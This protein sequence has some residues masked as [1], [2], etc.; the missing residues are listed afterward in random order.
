MQR[1]WLSLAR[2]LVDQ[3]DMDFSFGA[4]QEYNGEQALAFFGEGVLTTKTYPNPFIISMSGVSLGGTVGNGIAFDPNGQITRVDSSSTT[5]KTFTIQ[6]ADPSLAR[7]DLLVMRYKSTG[8]I[9]VPKPSDPIVNVSLNLIDD[10]ELAVVKGTAAGSPAYPAKGPLD[11]IL[12]GLR[13]PAGAT[14]GTSVSVDLT[15][16]EVCQGNAFALPVIKQEVPTGAVD[17]V[18]ATFLTSAVPLTAQSV[19]VFLDGVEVLPADYT[20]SSQTLVFVTPPSLGQI[21]SVY[22]V[23]NG[24]S[25]TNPLQGKTETPSGAVDG[26][27]KLFTLT[28]TPIDHD[29]TIVFD[30][31]VKVPSG[32]WALIQN[33]SNPSQIQFTT[34]PTAG[35][36]ITVFYFVNLM[37]TG[38]SG[39]GAAA[40][41]NATNVGT[42]TG[43][44]KALSSGVLQFKSLTAGSNITIVDDGLGNV[45]LSSS[46][47][48][49]GGR[50]NVSGS[51]ASPQIVN[52]A[53]GIAASASQR[54]AY[55]LKGQVSGGAQPV[56]A[57]PQVAAGAVIGDERLFV[58]TNDT[59]Y[60]IFQDG[61]GL[62][63]NGSKYLQNNTSLKLLWDGALW[64][65]F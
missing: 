31:G 32:N 10:F 46:G 40:V 18:N 12:T 1:N 59:D 16:R 37:A 30:N 4:V 9:P 29:S 51:A 13:V 41:T 53:V 21:P 14:V 48:A 55:F 54:G 44:F 43:L 47:G 60:P 27:N 58:G 42:G 22:Y 35:H 52:P 20:I 50:W 33:G 17:G 64:C 7:W 2:K 23:V 15:I 26:S 24:S 8:A 3:Y 39:G 57:T 65:E 63:L 25:S 28:G 6:T 5:L 56:T 36:S 34:A 11:I 45:T 38:F 61:N 19:I 62:K 49:G